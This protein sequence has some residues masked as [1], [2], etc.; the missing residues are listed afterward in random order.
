[1]KLQKRSNLEYPRIDPNKLVEKENSNYSNLTLVR[2]DWKGF[3]MWF[4]AAI[5][6]ILKPWPQ[7][8]WVKASFSTR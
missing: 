4:S 2:K 5:E 6:E 8:P 3:L 1:M 7:S